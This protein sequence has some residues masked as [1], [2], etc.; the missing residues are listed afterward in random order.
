MHKY[1]PIY[2]AKIKPWVLNALTG[3][4]DFLTTQ[5]FWDSFPKPIV[6]AP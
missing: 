2:T 5:D 1:M 4:P 3:Q 6:T